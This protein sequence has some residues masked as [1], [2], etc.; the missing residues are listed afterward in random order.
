MVTSEAYSVKDWIVYTGLGV[1]QI[2]GVEVKTISGVKS[3]YYKIKT[4]KCTVWIPID[5]INNEKLRPLSTPEELQLV[6]AVLR[7]SP[8]EMS[9]DPLIRRQNIRRVQIENTL[10]D[11]ARL[12]RDLQARKTIRGNLSLKESN[13]M[14]TLKERLVEEW[15]VVS[16]EDADRVASRLN[17]LL[18]YQRSSLKYR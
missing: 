5:Q 13:A 2:T 6:I 18:N 16:G 7:R 15:S 11:M 3:K 1:G 8:I 14:R 12:L 10:E 4:T 17:E 9:S